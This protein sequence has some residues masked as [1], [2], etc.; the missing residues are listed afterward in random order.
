MRQDRTIGLA[1]GHTKIKSW[2][3]VVNDAQ[4]LVRIDKKSGKTVNLHGKIWRERPV[5]KRLVV[6]CMAAIIK[7]SFTLIIQQKPNE[8]V[9]M[10]LKLVS[11]FK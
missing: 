7:L 9:F 2:S 3:L 6:L 1:R 5:G 8:V 4:K 10:K 11:Y